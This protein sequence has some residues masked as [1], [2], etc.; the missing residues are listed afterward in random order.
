MSTRSSSDTNV[1]ID[2]DGFNKMIKWTFVGRGG[3]KSDSFHSRESADRY[4]GITDM[5][6][7]EERIQPCFADRS[8]VTLPDMSNFIAYQKMIQEQMMHEQ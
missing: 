7:K 3:K 1:H 2:E 6:K 4:S 5:R 8:H